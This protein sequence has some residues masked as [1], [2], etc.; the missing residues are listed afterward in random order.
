MKTFLY[1]I[2]ITASAVVASACSSD[3][4][5]AWSNDYMNWPLQSTS[6]IECFNSVQGIPQKGL[7][8]DNQILVFHSDKDLSN[9]Y[10]SALSDDGEPIEL[11][12][13]YSDI[14]WSHQSLVLV[15]TQYSDD[16]FNL[17]QSQV[18]VFHSE[19]KYVIDI[20]PTIEWISG[21]SSCAYAT[22]I[23]VDSPDVT[24][25]NIAVIEQINMFDNGIV[26][27]DR[28]QYWIKTIK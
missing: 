2:V 21:G 27:S 10:L 23:I 7:Q 11:S 12:S 1:S 14:D 8:I 15:A 3:D 22:G 19:G 4:N 18:A 24:D 5:S 6:S 17:K 20:R 16:N 25:Q 13:L 26:Y 28:P 9:K